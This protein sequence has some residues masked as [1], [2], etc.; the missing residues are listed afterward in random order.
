MKPYKKT[1]QKQSKYFAMLLFVV[2]TLNIS[3]S[4]TSKQH[5]S[6]YKLTQQTTELNV[7]LT[8][9]LTSKTIDQNSTTRLLP[10]EKRA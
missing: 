3:S 7:L 10:D 1:M 6:D 9:R 2:H 5:T 4:F 8:S